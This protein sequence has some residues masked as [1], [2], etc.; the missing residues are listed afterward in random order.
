MSKAVQF[1]VTSEFG[2]KLWEGVSKVLKSAKVPVE[3]QK[4]DLKSCK[5]DSH[6]LAA[7]PSVSLAAA[8]Q[9][10]Q[11]AL[12]DNAHPLAQHLQD[13]QRKIAKFFET[14][15][16]DSLLGTLRLACDMAVAN[17][18]ERSVVTAV[19]KPLGPL[20][21][22]YDALLNALVKQE[23]D[24]RV[25]EFRLAG[26]SLETSPI[27]TYWPK[28]LMYPEGLAFVVVPP[29]KYGTELEQLLMGMGGGPAMAS[30]RLTTN[31][32]ECNI[33]TSGAADAT[34]NP[35][36]FLLAVVEMLSE[37]NLTTEADKLRAAVEKTLAKVVPQ[38]LPNG[39]ADLPTFLAALEKNC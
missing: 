26:V 28:M 5:L 30:Q 34:E 29:T 37:M 32:R 36:G 31:T 9:T 4:T 2:S 20:T 25:D 23:R 39:N 21:S 3:L 24:R 16:H 12:S 27:G 10:N 17:K 35:T 33:H 18:K 7:N 8:S 19:H 6:I 13:K 22:Q 15:A 11:V 1:L 38:G 14:E